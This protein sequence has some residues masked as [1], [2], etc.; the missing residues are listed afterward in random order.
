ME[1]SSGVSA[2]EVLPKEVSIQISML[3]KGRLS[4]RGLNRTRGRGRA[5]ALSVLELGCPRSP[6]GHQPPGPQAPRLDW[7]YTA[8]LGLQPANGNGATSLSSHG[9][10]PRSKSLPQ[11]TLNLLYTFNWHNVACKSYLSIHLYTSYWSC[12]P[13]EP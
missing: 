7:S 8:L 13:G 12:F 4:A 3:S 6:L 9:Q 2:S 1:H 11:V 5:N 10:G